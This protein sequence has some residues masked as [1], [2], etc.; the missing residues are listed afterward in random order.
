MG[1]LKELV[2]LI[3]NIRSCEYALFGEIKNTSL[4]VTSTCGYVT[5]NN[6]YKTDYVY[7]E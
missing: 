5:P 7:T 1:V 4:V 3:T 6:E 2:S